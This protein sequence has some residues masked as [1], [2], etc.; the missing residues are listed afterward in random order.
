MPKFNNAILIENIKMRMKKHG[1]NQKQLA[2][3]IGMS[4][5]NFNK[6]INQAE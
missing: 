1:E 6:A 4:Q 5:P 3:A 2:E